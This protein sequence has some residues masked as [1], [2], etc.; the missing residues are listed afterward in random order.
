MYHRFSPHLRSSQKYHPLIIHQLLTFMTVCE[1][2]L[3]PK[4]DQPTLTP[5]C[6]CW[7]Q[8]ASKGWPAAG[9]GG[10]G[11]HSQVGMEPYLSASLRFSATCPASTWESCSGGVLVQR[12][13]WSGGS[14]SPSPR[15]GR[16]S[17]SRP[18]HRGHCCSPGR[19][20]SC[21]SGVCSN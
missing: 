10:C 6:C 17:H 19:S 2:W 7:L 3:R 11:G 20:V 1:K 18:S 5:C 15:W 8:W 9:A 21:H 4:S 16:D 12:G 13:S 14:A